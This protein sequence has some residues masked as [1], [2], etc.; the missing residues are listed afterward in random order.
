MPKFEMPEKC[1]E[2]FVAKKCKMQKWVYC[3]KHWKDRLLF[4][5]NDS[6]KPL[7]YLQLPLNKLFLEQNI[8]DWDDKQ[9]R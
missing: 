5:F 1:G 7:S 3:V 8:T 2:I 6:I 9:I 4:C